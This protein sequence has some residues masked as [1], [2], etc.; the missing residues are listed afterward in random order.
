MQILH[1][2]GGRAELSTPEVW[3]VQRDFLPMS[4]VWKGGGGQG[5]VTLQQRN[6]KIAQAGDR[7]QYQRDKSRSQHVPLIGCDEKGTLPL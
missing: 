5:R 6:L 7:R 1:P 3:T 4:A 2:K